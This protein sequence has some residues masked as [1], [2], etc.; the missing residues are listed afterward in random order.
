MKYITPKKIILTA[1]IFFFVLVVKAQPE[2]N[3][4]DPPESDVPLDGGITLLIAA[5]VG[6]G[7]RKYR[8][9]RRKIKKEEELK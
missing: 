7:A 5:G 1:I 2:E 3:G 6:Y 8:N 9:E 4:G